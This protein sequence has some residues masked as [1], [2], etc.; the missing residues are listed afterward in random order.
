MGSTIGKVLKRAEEMSAHGA[1]LH[2]YSRHGIEEADFAVA[3]EQLRRMKE[4]YEEW[5]RGAEQ[6]R[7]QG[8]IIG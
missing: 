8:A 7:R 6:G 4:E 3:F 5:G 2:W 1:Y